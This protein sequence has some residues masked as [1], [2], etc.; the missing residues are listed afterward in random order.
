[1]ELCNG[2]TEL[3]DP[4]EQRNRFEAELDMRKQK[5]EPIPPLPE[6]FLSELKF[7]PPSA[8]NALGIDR[9]VMLFANAASI[10]EV[11]AFLPEEL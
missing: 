4:D 7:M 11:V 9:L 8:G 6:K 2:F 3:T 10:D 1:L 5:G